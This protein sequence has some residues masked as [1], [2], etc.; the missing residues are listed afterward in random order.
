MGP[1]PYGHVRTLCRA[2]SRLSRGGMRL[3]DP[4]GVLP[5]GRR[6]L[7]SPPGH[8]ADKPRPHRANGLVGG[9]RSGGPGGGKS[10]RLYL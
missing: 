6:P 2:R 10:M 7:E 5:F 3:W 4:A 8:L 9:K 1:F